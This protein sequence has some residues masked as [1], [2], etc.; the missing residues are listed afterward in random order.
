VAAINSQGTG[1][2]TSS[3]NTNVLGVP[4]APT[5]ISS[6]SN[7][8]SITLT[9]TAP[10]NNGGSPVTDYYFE[11]STDNTNTIPISHTPSNATTYTFTGLDSG[12]TYY[13]H[14][15]A[16]NAQ[17]TS[18]NANASETTLTP[19]AVDSLR[20][21]AKTFNSISLEWDTPQLY[22]ATVQGYQI[23]YT[24]PFGT[25]QTKIINSTNF[26][27]TSYQ[28]IDLVPGTEYSFR[29]GMWT[30]SGGL[31]A[32]GNTLN[33]QTYQNANYTIGQFST[34]AQN[35]N[36]IGIK[37][38]Q[39]TTQNGRALYVT[40][41]TTYDLGCDFNYKF[42]QQNQTYDNISGVPI[43]EGRKQATFLFNG[44]SNEVISA[45]CFDQ[46]SADSSQMT[47]T[48]TDFALLTQIQNFRNGTYGTTGQFG[49]L[50]LV[51]VL[52]VFL[53]MIGFNR[54]NP[55]A[56]VLFATAT[57]FGLAYFGIISPITS[58]VSIVVAVIFMLAVIGTRRQD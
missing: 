45:K 53:S 31:N 14:V 33:V 34:G 52:I 30:Y 54:L 46:N 7:A 50:D 35:P 5:G 3:A 2:Y 23:N 20:L 40:Y 9:W 19:Q 21:T 17:G 26:A 24:T 16:V 41:P 10:S 56:G 6:T 36:Q 58:G 13:F 27:G 22:G 28:V 18:T 49:A 47:L 15:A 51:T 39:E 38:A 12:T 1:A 55:A 25:P 43:S 42:S 57:M 48:S 11:Y 37:M 29:I 32:G 4:D 44:T 8:V